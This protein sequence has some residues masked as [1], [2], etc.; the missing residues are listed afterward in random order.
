MKLARNTIAITV[1]SIIS[2]GAMSSAFAQDNSQLIASAGLS[3]SEAQGLTLNEIAAAKFNQGE[4]RP[5]RQVILSPERVAV[6]PARHAQLIAAAGLTAEEAEGLSISALGVAK[7]NTGADNDEQQAQRFM[8]SRGPIEMAPPQFAATAG[9]S[10]E[11]ARGLTL[12]EIYAIKLAGGNN[13]QY[14]N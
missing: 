11:E 8:F 6:D 13:G 7:H 1:A 3:Q 10:P 4:S 9:L 14:E 5:D 12:N 2:F